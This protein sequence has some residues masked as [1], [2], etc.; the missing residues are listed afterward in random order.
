MS[1]TEETISS[2]L[3]RAEY[4]NWPFGDEFGTREAV[5]SHA[6]ID[7]IERGGEIYLSEVADSCGSGRIA[8]R[9]LVQIIYHTIRR[10]EME[11]GDI[12]NAM[13]EKEIDAAIAA[14]GS[15]LL[16]LAVSIPL[17]AMI[18]GSE[19]VLKKV[20]EAEAEAAA[21]AP[22]VEDGESAEGK[23]E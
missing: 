10:W 21:N 6:A 12:R 4:F 14:A 2:K 22:P 15:R 13:D 5:L 18:M 8:R 7:D 3:F 20:A 23:E 19:H 17:M 9:D 11:N 16:I 1:E